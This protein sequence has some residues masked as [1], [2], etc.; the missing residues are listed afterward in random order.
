M[1]DQDEHL[2][3]SRAFDAP[4]AE[5]DSS[6]DDALRAEL[7]GVQQ[8]N[9]VI[10]GVLSSL[11]KAKDNMETVSSTV[12]NANNLL[13]LWIKIL[14]QTDHT[15]RL[16]QS[17]HWEGASKELEN[18]QAETQ[19]KQREVQRRAEEARERAAARE[20]DAAA[21][22]ARRLAAEKKPTGRV[23]TRRGATGTSSGR[24]AAG[25]SRTGTGSY[26]S[27]SSSSTRGAPTPRLTRGGIGRGAYGTGTARGTRGA[28]GGAS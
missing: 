9:G 23:G 26:T 7:R 4:T 6:R 5:A 25:G 22:E 21:T 24:G 17:R 27:N 15:Q 16:L 11:G 19:A 14:S 20:R 8:V 3:R 18:I 1:A 12:E 10:E 13:N 2:H 28:R